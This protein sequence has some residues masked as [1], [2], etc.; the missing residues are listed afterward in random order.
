MNKDNLTE[1]IQGIVEKAH[2]ISWPEFVALPEKEK[3]I[4]LN[5]SQ[6]G[7]PFHVLFSQ[8]FNRDNLNLLC[9]VAE[10]ARL[11]HKNRLEGRRF[12]KELLLA[13][14]P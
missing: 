10:R 13:L 8:Q 7:K 3:I 11:I 5:N 4:F 9:Q 1:S 12:L 2:Q 14:T 6:T